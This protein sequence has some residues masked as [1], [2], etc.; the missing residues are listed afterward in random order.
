M[1]KPRILIVD[2]EQS[3]RR[4][5]SLILRQKGYDTD[6]AETGG[7]ALSKAQEGAFDLVILEIRLPDVSGTELIAPLQ[8]IHPDIATI[9][10]SGYG[11]HEDAVQALNQGASAYVNKP[12]NLVELGAVIERIFE[13]RRLEV[14]NQKHHE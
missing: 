1:D 13:K 7:E 3:S 10:T 5:L 11:T 6:T 12:I 2:D 14:E 4:S 9:M 8:G